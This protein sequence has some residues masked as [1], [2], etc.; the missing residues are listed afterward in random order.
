MPPTILVV[1]DDLELRRVLAHALMEAGYEVA[2]ASDGLMALQRIATQAPDL[3]LSDVRMPR[4]DGIELATLLAP[5]TPPIPIILMSG[6]PLPDGCLL[7]FL[8][9]PF[10]VET[11]LT[12]MARTL[13]VSNVT[14][15]ALAGLGA[16]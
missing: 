2:E 15:V 4:L 12:V 1:D 13:P 3:I 10:E 7:P 6:N 14:I 9:K 16:V 5:H 11:L 8:G